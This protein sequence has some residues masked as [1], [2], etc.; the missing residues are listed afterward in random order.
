MNMAITNGSAPTGKAAATSTNGAAGTAQGGG[1]A[2][3]LVQAIEGGNPSAGVNAGTALPVGLAG[4]LGQN[5]LQA[6]AEQTQDLLAML[7]NLI[8]Q[9][10]KLEDSEAALPPE[11]EEQLAALLA[12]LQQLL[13]QLQPEQPNEEATAG[14]PVVG[15]DPETTAS[16]AMLASDKPVVKQLRETLQRI[17]DAIATA[18][19]VPEQTTA[20]FAQLKTALQAAE[21]GVAVRATQG[22]N[23]A[24][25]AKS[26]QA[27]AASENGAEQGNP[28]A[29]EASSQ[30]GSPTDVRRSAQAFRDPVW[31]YQVGSAGEAA[32]ANAQTASTTTAAS[33]ESTQSADAQPIWTF[34]QNDAFS[35]AEAQAVKAA[36]IPTP[37]PVQQFA[38]QMSKFLV[39]QFQLTQGNGTTEAKLTL[40]PEHL[41][42]VD[43]RIVM[44]NGTLTAQFIADNP[45]ARDMLENQMAQ[46][47]A[48]LNGQGLQVDRIDVLQQPPTSSG[49][50]F[51]QQEHRNPNSRGGNGSSGN[52]GGDGLEDPAVFAAE[53]ER[54]SSLKEAGYGSSINV[55]A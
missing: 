31:R 2:G 25:A 37:V 21:E 47:R 4:L 18:K 19:N 14:A 8:E 54:N 44:H 34:Q 16:A 11:A 49:T 52:D 3:A 53:L 5:G 23:E 28:A 1:F 33:A 43:I 46:L 9:L 7:A 55:T 36:P 50:S 12:S 29:K 15:A 51:A 32:Q 26:G 22:A 24:E 45:A 6:S 38:D 35:K 20:L 17:S 41:G 10:Q 39:K 30:A 27:K 40:T 48:S 13:A 42:Q